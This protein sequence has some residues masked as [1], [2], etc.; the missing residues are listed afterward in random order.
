MILENLG[1]IILGITC[2]WLVIWFLRKR[3]V[4]GL[5]FKEG[6]KIVAM[7]LNGKREI[8]GVV[9]SINCGFCELIDDGGH[10]VYVS[11]SI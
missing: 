7:P 1:E 9:K 11:T 10:R 5:W 6:D 4:Y 2:F 3:S 8:A